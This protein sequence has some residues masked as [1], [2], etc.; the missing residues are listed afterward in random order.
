MENFLDT[1]NQ[2]NR[3]HNFVGGVLELV[4]YAA[5]NQNLESIDKKVLAEVLG[6]ASD[7]IDET[8]TLID[9]FYQD[10]R[11]KQGFSKVGNTR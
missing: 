5:S 3:N 4:L 1:I 10:W 7:A 8:A 6:R 2:V 9:G 11:E